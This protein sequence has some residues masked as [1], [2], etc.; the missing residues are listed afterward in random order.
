MKVY[1]NLPEELLNGIEVDEE[2]IEA[3][4]VEVEGEEVAADPEAVG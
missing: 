4:E 2:N 3:E 1:S